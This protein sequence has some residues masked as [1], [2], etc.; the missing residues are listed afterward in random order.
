[1]DQDFLLFQRLGYWAATISDDGP[2]EI[3]TEML[4]DLSHTS[5]WLEHCSAEAA[6]FWCGRWNS[7]PR[8]TR[9][10]VDEH[11]LKVPP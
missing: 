1:M 4:A 5:F 3:A 8:A 9:Y 7:L 10:T 2:V 11:T 6:R